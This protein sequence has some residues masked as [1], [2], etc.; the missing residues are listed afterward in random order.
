MAEK[1]VFPTVVTSTTITRYF[2]VH[3]VFGTNAETNDPE[4][5]YCIQHT[6]SGRRKLKTCQYLEK[7]GTDQ[8]R[9]LSPTETLD[10][11]IR[12]TFTKV[13]FEEST[14]P[15]RRKGGRETVTVTTEGANLVAVEI[16]QAMEKVNCK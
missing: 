14:T 15:N 6:G 9:V 11:P 10:A 2:D 1:T 3:A 12:H 4:V 7:F 5:W 13:P 16:Q 8:Y